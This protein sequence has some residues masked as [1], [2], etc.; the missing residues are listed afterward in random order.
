[1]ATSNRKRAAKAGASNRVAALLEAAK[2]VAF[3]QRGGGDQPSQTH[4][5]INNRMMTAYDGVLTIGMPIEEE[6]TACP[7]TKLF[8]KAMAACGEN[9]TLTMQDPTTLIVRSGKFRAKV[10]CLLPKDMPSP[11]PDA[12]VAACGQSLVDSILTVAPLATEGARRVLQASVLLEDACA[13]A[14]DGI[15]MLQAYHGISMPPSL[16][17]PKAFASALAKMPGV[18]QGF[19]YSPSTF[20]LHYTNGA[21]VKC[22]RFVEGWPNP[23]TVLDQY[24]SLNYI[25]VPEGLVEAIG[26]V[27]PFSENGDVYLTGEKSVISS[28]PNGSGDGVIEY[29]GLPTAV[30][31]GYSAKA[32]ELCSGFLKRWDITTATGSRKIMFF[33]NGATVRGAIVGIGDN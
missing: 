28:G 18:V 15:A 13:T 27:A 7:N 5:V 33:A 11:L 14:S 6:F 16:I 12:Q 29:D 22:Q 2:I 17:L 31:V 25:D 9:F 24:P 3:A 10:P 30:R 26:Q 4:C 8:A 23:S 19:G 32:I 21:F 1:M 20:T